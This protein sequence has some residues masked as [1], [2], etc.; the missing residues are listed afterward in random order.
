MTAFNHKQVSERLK[1][2]L[3]EN[4]VATNYG[5]Y[6]GI[7]NMPLETLIMLK[8]LCDLAIQEKALELVN[9]KI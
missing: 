4:A 9:D 5:D 6:A 8:A 1:E 7:K 3:E 2:F